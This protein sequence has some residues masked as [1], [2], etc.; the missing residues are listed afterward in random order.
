MVTGIE[1][2]IPVLEFDLYHLYVKMHIIKFF[3]LKQHFFI[4]GKL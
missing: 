3:Y 2:K 1:N 4:N